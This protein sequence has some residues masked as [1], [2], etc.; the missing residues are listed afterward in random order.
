[1]RRE[2]Y[3]NLI[4]LTFFDCFKGIGKIK[5]RKRFHGSRNIQRMPFNQARYPQKCNKGRFRRNQQRRLVSGWAEV[6]GF[7]NA[8]IARLHKR[9]QQVAQF[10]SLVPVSSTAAVMSLMTVRIVP[11]TGRTTPLYA[12]LRAS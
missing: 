4:I 5:F 9:N 1:M 7:A 12:V 3:H 2:V 8:F 11:S 10:D 6:P